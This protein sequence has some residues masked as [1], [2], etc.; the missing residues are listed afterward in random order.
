MTQ[1]PP[2]TFD[3]ATWSGQFAE[4]AACTQA[5]GQGWFDRASLIC[6]NQLCNPANWPTATLQTLLY[7]LT[8]HIAWLNAPRDANGN[9]AA[10]GAPPPPVVGRINSFSEGSASGGADMGDA[11]V[12]SPSQA[13]YM[14]TKYGAEF[15]AST[16]SFR[17]AQYVP[18]PRFFGPFS[19]FG[20][21]GGVFTRGR[22][23][24]L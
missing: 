24:V 7:L 22:G 17:T 18:G 3:F 23:G 15:W 9:P 13:W 16:A 6:A 11:N 21:Y 1:A 10:T 12:G 4:F 5:Q 19:G 14:Q 20:P 2:V 8:S